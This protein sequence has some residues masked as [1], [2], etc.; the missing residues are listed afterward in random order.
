[1]AT[2]PVPDFVPPPDFPALS[3]RALGTY[4]SKAYAWATAIQDSTGP[5]IHAIAVTAKSNADAAAANTI[6]ADEDRVQ[7][8]LDRA[9]TA[10]D[11]VQ[12][13]LDRAQTGLDRTAAA[14]S[15][16]QASKLNLGNKSTP[17]TL[18][19]QGEALL[20]G[21]TY[22]DTTLGKWRV[23]TG[24]AWGDGIST[25]AGVSSIDGQSG[26]LT[27]KMINGLAL[28]GAGNIETGAS[29]YRVARTS[30]TQLAT[31]DKGKLLDIISGTFTQSFAAAAALGDGWWCYLRNSG[32]GDITLDPNASDLI[33]GLSSYVMYPGEC[34][35]LQCDGAALRSVVLNGFYKTFTASGTFTK[36]PGYAKFWLLAWSGG[37]SGQRTNN[38]TSYSLGGGGGGSFH[39]T[40]SA[41]S[42]G[43]SESVVIGAGGAAVSAIAN[44]NIGGDTSFGALLT[45][46]S[47]K[48]FNCG[49]SVIRS[50]YA[51]AGEVA[52][53][54]GSGNTISANKTIYGGGG[55]GY[56][57]SSNAEPS[58]YG[59]GSGGSF[60]AGGAAYNRGV[61]VSQFGG[62]GGAAGAATNG[63][64]GSAP[65]GG[66]GATQTGAQ[67]GAGARGE[68]RIW[69]VI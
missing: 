62:N 42:V 3:D 25:V 66:G 46:Y 41:S 5:N 26:P 55:I 14:D 28:L 38:D 2:T 24:A 59:G 33:D 35:L 56:N 36:P 53:Y 49:G 60:G 45:V 39:T 43:A 64:A 6:L 32:T 10:A 29:L 58:V 34:R 9:A 22:Y 19:N 48:L 57:A 54:S 31:A 12:T 65:G 20:A 8:G 47:G 51:V 18:D 40:L 30:N 17:P 50:A 27:L 11:R 13:G 7:T 16:V 69:G 63:I 37:N 1:M 23:W 21:S 61:G 68:L 44:G 4:N 15:A 67:S 52:A